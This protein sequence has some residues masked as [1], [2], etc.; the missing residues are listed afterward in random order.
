MK[1]ISK[2]FLHFWKILG[3]G[4]VTGVIGPGLLVIPVLSGS[5]SY[6]VTK[7]FGREEGLPLF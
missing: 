4:L 2:K 6:I 5:L 1:R 3:P 7:T